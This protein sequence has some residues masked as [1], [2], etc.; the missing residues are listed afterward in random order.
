MSKVK[1]K[2]MKVKK[3]VKDV[4]LLDEKIDCIEYEANLTTCPE[5]KKENLNIYIDNKVVYG[6]ISYGIDG[7]ESCPKCGLKTFFKEM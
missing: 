3:L 6:G 5:C 1:Q 4:L 2:K 7:S